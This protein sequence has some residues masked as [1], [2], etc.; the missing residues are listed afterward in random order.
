MESLVPLRRLAA[1]LVEGRSMD[2]LDGAPWG[3][4]GSELDRLHADG[5]DAGRMMSIEMR[6]VKSM[7]WP[8]TT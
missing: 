2:S 8:E 3:V 5:D 4:L 7:R 1:D 6:S